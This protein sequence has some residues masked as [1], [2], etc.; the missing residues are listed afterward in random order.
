MKRKIFI[1][2]I[3]ICLVTLTAC[4]RSKTIKCGIGKDISKTI[5]EFS[6]GSK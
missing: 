1:L 3:I 6:L 5:K 4:T 2:F